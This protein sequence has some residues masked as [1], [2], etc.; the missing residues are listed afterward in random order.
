[1]VDV[2]CL[3]YLILLLY[4]DQY[5]NK[6]TGILLVRLDLA[7]SKAGTEGQLVVSSTI[8]IS[9]DVRTL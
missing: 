9:C 2:Q 3:N 6:H 7:P 1:M 4:Y 5:Y 8:V